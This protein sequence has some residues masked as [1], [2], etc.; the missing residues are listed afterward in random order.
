MILAGGRGAR[1]GEIDK[2]LVRLRGRPLVDH[3]AATLAP[4]VAHLLVSA[5]RNADS[6]ARYAPVLADDPAHGAWQGPLAGIA[7]GLAGSP[8]PWVVTAPCDTPFLP[9]DLVARLAAA[10]RADSVTD[11]AV[12]GCATDRATAGA[13]GGAPRIAVAHAGG[14]RQSVC[15]LL[16]VDLLPALRAYLDAG[17]RKVDRWQDAHG[18]IEVD[19]GDAAAF[20][21]LN[22]A[23]ELAQAEKITAGVA[24]P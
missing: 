2:G 15:M 16:P 5:N 9:Q 12:A 7:A 20:M 11:A 13:H 17:E 6:Y 8:L 18:C 23:D 1:M 24:K 4:Q 14:R 22:T 19:C 21:N 10:L 3:V